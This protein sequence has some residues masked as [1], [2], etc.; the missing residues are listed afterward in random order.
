MGWFSP[1][2]SLCTRGDL[3]SYRESGV[4]A[5]LNGGYKFTGAYLRARACVSVSVLIER[6][7][8][9][10]VRPLTAV[11]WCNFAE[12]SIE[13]ETRVYYSSAGK[14]LLRS[15]LFTVH[16]RIRDARSATLW[17]SVC[18]LVIYLLYISAL[19]DPVK[20]IASRL[21]AENEQTAAGVRCKMNCII[22][23]FFSPLPPLA[24][25]C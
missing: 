7:D 18:A 5:A 23:S 21:F 9:L 15:R 17:L 4:I 6:G 13:K 11:E 20:N 25:L 19:G 8:V 1:S 12:S 22:Y 3:A 2:V 10:A 24:P 16:A 14:L